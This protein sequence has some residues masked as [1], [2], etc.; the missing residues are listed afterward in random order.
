M[1]YQYAALIQWWDCAAEGQIENCIVWRY[2]WTNGSKFFHKKL[3]YWVNIIC[4]IC[5]I[6][7]GISFF[8][9]SLN[10]RFC[11]FK[12]QIV[13]WVFPILIVVAY[14]YRVRMLVLELQWYVCLKWYDWIE[15]GIKVTIKCKCFWQCFRV[16]RM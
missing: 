10:Y 1:W 5:S 7:L 11:F 3:H 2:H 8:T 13:D 15:L 4:V 12:R 16:V 6:L 9:V 14:L